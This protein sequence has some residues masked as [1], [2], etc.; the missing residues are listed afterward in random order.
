MFLGVPLRGKS[1]DFSSRRKYM[2]KGVGPKPV[3]ESDSSEESAPMPVPTTP[4]IRK[5]FCE[6]WLWDMFSERCVETEY[7]VCV[8]ELHVLC[9]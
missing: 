8:F 1:A 2:R 4:T 3:P 5:E 7:D 6:T 9:V